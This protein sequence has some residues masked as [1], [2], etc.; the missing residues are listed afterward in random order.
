[1]D[2]YLQKAKSA[3]EEA[4]QGMTPEQL[5][6]H[7]DGKWCAAEVL[8]HL[9]LAF[10]GT[11]KML[12]RVLDTGKPMVTRKTPFQMVGT[13]LITGLGVFPGGRKAPAGVTPKGIDSS[14]AV[15]EILANLQAMDERLTKC[16]AKFGNQQQVADHPVLGALKIAQWRRFHCVHTQHHMKQIHRL[17]MMQRLP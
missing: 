6:W 2:V 9:S 15:G 7:P 14:K 17:R 3:I 12:G 8:E 1:M 10:G 13:F 5:A 4:T 16:D 11:A